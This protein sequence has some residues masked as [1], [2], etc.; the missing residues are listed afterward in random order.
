MLMLLQAAEGESD[1]EEMIVPATSS[2]ISREVGHGFLSFTDLVITYDNCRVYPIAVV[3]SCY[4]LFECLLAQLV[5]YISYF[6][7]VFQTVFAHVIYN[8]IK[9]THFVTQHTLQRYGMMLV[10]LSLV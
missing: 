8:D 10:P 1:L 4:S 3:S 9:H 5:V 2:A 7:Y 6:H